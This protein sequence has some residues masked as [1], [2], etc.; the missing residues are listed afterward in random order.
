M[1]ANTKMAT[2]ESD[3]PTQALRYDVIDELSGFDSWRTWSITRLIAYIALLLRRGAENQQ[4]RMELHNK[5]YDRWRAKY[6]AFQAKMAGFQP[7]EKP[8]D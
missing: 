3:A 1:N 2:W 6:E 8:N 7:K 4:S 5:R